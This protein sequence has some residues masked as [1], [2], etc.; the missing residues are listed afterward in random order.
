MKRLFY[1]LTGTVLF[2]ALMISCNKT[3][4]TGIEIAQSTLILNYWTKCNNHSKF[5]ALRCY[6]KNYLDY[7]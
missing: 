6:R 7:K 1:F 5:E 3:K 4:I 2:F